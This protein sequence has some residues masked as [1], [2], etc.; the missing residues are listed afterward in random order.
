MQEVWER[1][2][3]M[4][5]YAGSPAE[6][7]IGKLVKFKIPG[8]NGPRAIS[9]TVTRMRLADGKI[10]VRAQAGGYYVIKINEIIGPC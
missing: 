1:A 9:G 5:E 2:M 6:Q 3:G 10:E 7:E 4:T 8:L